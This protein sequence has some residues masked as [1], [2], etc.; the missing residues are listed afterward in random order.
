M[1]ARHAVLLAFQASILCTVFGLGLS[2]TSRDLAYLLHRPALFARSVLAMLVIM[3]AVAV[4]LARAFDFRPTVEI[5]LVALALSPVPPLLPQRETKAGGQ[6]TYGLGLMAALALVSIASIPLSLEILERVFGR[7]FAMTPASIAK[8]VLMFILAP[9]LAGVAVRVVLPGI[10]DRI[11]RLV[12]WVP[13]VLLPLAGVALLA[14]T[15]R[16]LWDAIGEG[17][18]VAILVFVMAGV[19][20]GHLLGR[21]EPEHSLV[22]ALSSACR[23]PAIALSM[24][25]ANYPDLRFGGTILLYLVVSLAVTMVYV[26]WQRRRVTRAAHPQPRSRRAA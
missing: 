5:A 12:S 6:R 10:A 15:W 8:V 1:D 20:V 14:G 9:L 3:P 22:L 18:V 16:M 24:A 19:V 4:T 21:P 26:A 13:K 17:T 7:T 11:A 23:H 2:A 25:T